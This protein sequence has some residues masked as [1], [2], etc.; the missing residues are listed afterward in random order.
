MAAQVRGD[1]TLVVGSRVSLF[2][3]DVYYN[4]VFHPTYDVGPDDRGFAM[5]RPLSTSSSFD[6]TVVEHWTQEPGLAR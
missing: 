5:I 4:F 3:V 6:I 1:S 2:P